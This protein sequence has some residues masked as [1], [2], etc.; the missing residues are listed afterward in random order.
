MKNFFAKIDTTSRRTGAKGVALVLVTFVIALASIVVVNLTYSTYLAARSN[1]VIEQSLMAEYLLKSVINLGRAYLMI[2]KKSS[3]SDGQNE[4]WAKFTQGVEI[5]LETFGI[6]TPGLKISL[7]L[8]PENKRVFLGMLVDDSGNP[9]S[10]ERINFIVRLFQR[11]GFDSDLKETDNISKFFKGK[12]FNSKE[13]V[14]NLI[15]YMDSDPSSYKSQTDPNFPQG[16]EGSLPKNLFPNRPPQSTSELLMIPGFTANRIRKLEPYVTFFD[17]RDSSAGAVGAGSDNS[18][19][20]VN[21]APILILTALSPNITR[22]QIDQ[23]IEARADKE[24]TLNTAALQQILGS[25]W[26]NVVN[27][28][29]TRSSRFQVIGKVELGAKSYYTRAYL[30][31]DDSIGANGLPNIEIQSVQYY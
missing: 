1:A 21:F 25:E 14:A 16:I 10:D 11:L 26:N 8:T 31:R 9:A 23:I 4:P 20:N 12:H 18:K 6:R 3:D 5:P 15:D 24:K 7:E 29:S 17:A 19:V 30:L 27:F 28:V 2:D 13:I 22:N